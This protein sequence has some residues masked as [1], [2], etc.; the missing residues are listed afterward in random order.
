M[1]YKLHQTLDFLL[2]RG[3]ISADRF[4]AKSVEKNKVLAL[5]CKNY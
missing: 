3:I 4:Y 2:R 5:E 1:L